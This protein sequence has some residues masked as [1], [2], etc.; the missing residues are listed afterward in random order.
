MAAPVRIGVIFPGQGSQVVGMGVDVAAAS[1]AAA[2]LFARAE[3]VVGYDLLELCRQGPEDRLRE[4]RYSQPAIFVTNCALAVA[5]NLSVAVSAGHSFGEYCS[6]VLSN[7][8]EFEEALELVNARGIAMQRA[9]EMAAGSMS[10]I[11]GLDAAKI[12]TAVAQAR[13]EGAGRVSLAN[14]NAPAQ[15]VISGDVGAVRRAGEL[16]VEAGAK[17]VIPLNVSGAWHSEL[18]QPA[19]PL[20]APAVERAHISVPS[21]IVVSNVDAQPYRDV[22]HI[23]EN[24]VRSV[25]EEVLWHATSLRLLSDGKPELV[26]E[27]GASSVLASMLKRLPNAPEVMS[28]ADF[29]GVQRLHAKLGAAVTR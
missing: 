26:I 17:R 19:V 2:D 1:K 20:F 28:V 16:C 13:A 22:A 7:S 9:A 27:F 23:K 25:T 6:L 4:T 8:L 29:S 5:A 11:I 12:E 15:I 24:L 18:M 3:R 21:F 14:F 10:A